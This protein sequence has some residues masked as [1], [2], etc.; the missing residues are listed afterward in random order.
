[1]PDSFMNLK[2]V[3]FPVSIVLLTAS[4]AAEPLLDAIRAQP[5][6]IVL[7]DGRLLS[8]VLGIREGRE[9]SNSLRRAIVYLLTASFG[10]IGLIALGTVADQPLPLGGLQILLLNVAVHVFPALAL[11]TSA[12]AAQETSVP[13]RAPLPPRDMA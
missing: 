7:A 4:Q 10:T 2:S 8:L 9:V 3:L 12:E 11:A 6:H 1:M 5:A 13:T